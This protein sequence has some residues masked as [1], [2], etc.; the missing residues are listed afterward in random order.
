MVGVWAKKYKEFIK[1]FQTPRALFI[2]LSSWLE[3]NPVFEGAV[4][5]KGNI[6]LLSY[7]CCCY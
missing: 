3:T 7:I 6:E 4:S 2:P 1:K 5:K